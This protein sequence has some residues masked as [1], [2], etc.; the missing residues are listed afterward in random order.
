MEFSICEVAHF[1]KDAL[2]YEDPITFDESFSD[3]QFRKTVIGE[4]FDFTSLEEGIQKTVDW[5]LKN[6]D[7]LRV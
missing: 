1:I 6:L 4:D 3:G 5:Y 2:G 7:K